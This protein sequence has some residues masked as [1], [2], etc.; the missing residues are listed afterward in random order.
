LKTLHSIFLFSLLFLA[1]TPG[2][3]QSERL[4]QVPFT[5]TF[6]I[7]GGF[8]DEPVQ[9]ELHSLPGATILFT[10]NGNDP[11]SNSAIPYTGPIIIKKNTVIRAIAFRGRERSPY[12]ANSYFIGEPKSTF[13]TASLI[14]PPGVLFD[15]VDGMYRKGPRVIDSLYKKPGA[16]FWSRLEVPAHLQ[17]FEPNGRE[18]F[19]SR[20]GFRLFGGLSR[21]LP[22]KSFAVVARKQYGEKRI[23]A[24]VFGKGILPENSNTWH[25]VMGEVILAIAIF[26]IH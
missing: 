5:V 14:I 10:T 24:K 22:Q 20:I 9:V 1:L 11:Q 16:N 2:H 6:S 12:F 3:C 7:E 25:F 13:P 23:K 8:Y 15:P 18:W 19:N 21:L 4:N 17:L 26:E